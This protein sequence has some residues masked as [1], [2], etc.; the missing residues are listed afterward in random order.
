ME[1]S[2]E[3]DSVSEICKDELFY[4]EAVHAGVHICQML[5]GK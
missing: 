2:A 1:A 4:A 5:F 3:Q